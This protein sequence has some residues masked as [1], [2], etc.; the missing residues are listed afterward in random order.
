M[1]IQTKILEIIEQAVKDKDGNKIFIDYAKVKTNLIKELKTLTGLDFNG[2]VHSL[3][4]AGINHALKH[5]NIKHSDI[6][7]IPF[8]VEN[9]DLIGIGKEPNTI[10]YK[11]LIGEEYF[12]IEE[13]RTGRK[14]FTIKT[15]Y[16]RKKRQK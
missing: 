14:K 7:L 8:I 1:D 13:I 2:Y 6:L 5:A 16:K 9:Y 11:K 4:A 10:V 12:C 15:F 3:D